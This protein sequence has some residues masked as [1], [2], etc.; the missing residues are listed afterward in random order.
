MQSQP[1]AYNPPMHQQCMST[2]FAKPGDVPMGDDYATFN[3]NQYNSIQEEFVTDGMLS[4]PDK[5]TG[6]AKRHNQSLDVYNK[7]SIH[8]GSITITNKT[9][10]YDELQSIF[11]H[12]KE[13]IDEQ[14]QREQLLKKMAD[15]YET[16]LTQ[17][18]QTIPNQ[19]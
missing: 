4:S 13:W 6:A 19:H 2:D 7:Q 16:S 9:D 1:E 5:K 8:H 11:N 10:L 12:N 18:H 15:Y 14:N 3:V 17:G